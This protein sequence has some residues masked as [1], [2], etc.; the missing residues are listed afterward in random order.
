MDR[1]GIVYL[2]SL[3]FVQIVDGPL[4]QIPDFIVSSVV[5]EESRGIYGGSGAEAQVSIFIYNI[6]CSPSR[7]CRPMVAKAPMQHRKQRRRRAAQGP[8]ETAK[9]IIEHRIEG[10]LQA[11]LLYKEDIVQK[12]SQA[13]LTGRA[14]CCR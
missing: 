4:K 1:P 5:T 6:Y 8:P 14:H 7:P 13:C 10:K 9:G 3:G 12:T 11:R 2:I